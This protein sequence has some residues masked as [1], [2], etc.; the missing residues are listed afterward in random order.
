MILLNFNWSPI[1]F[2]LYGEYLMKEALAEVG[3]FK[4]GGRIINKF[5]SVDDTTIITKTREGL[6]DTIDTGRKYGIKINI[7]ISQVVRLSRSN[8]SLQIK[9]NNREL[10]EVD[11]FKYL[12]WKCA[13]KRG[14]LHKGNQDENCQ[15]GDI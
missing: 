4:I 14:L 7:D 12:G 10:K 1:L 8:E 11:H 6:Q 9:V 2:N 13:N 15:I 3:D 5:R